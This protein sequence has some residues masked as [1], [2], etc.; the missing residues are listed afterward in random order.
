M[1]MQ[2]SQ[3]DAMQHLQ[4]RIETQGRGQGA[5]LIEPLL[6]FCLLF[7]IPL[8]HTFSGSSDPHAGQ[9]VWDLSHP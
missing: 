4:V 8:C 2:V 5:E 7:Y 1:F 3:T 6:H 9:L